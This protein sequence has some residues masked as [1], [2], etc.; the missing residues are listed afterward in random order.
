MEDAFGFSDLKVDK[1][2]RYSGDIFDCIHV[3][4]VRK[5]I[6]DTLMNAYFENKICLEKAHPDKV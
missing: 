3:F 1:I 4:I 2:V 5:Y 6:V